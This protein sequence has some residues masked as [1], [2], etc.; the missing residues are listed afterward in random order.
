MRRFLVNTSD[1][2]GATAVV[3]GPDAHHITNV[4]RLARG[5]EIELLDGSGR[6]YSA[7][8]VSV[9]SQKVEVELLGRTPFFGESPL[10]LTVAQAYLKSKKMD[11]LIRQLTELGIAAWLP[12]VSQRSVPRPDRKSLA[13]RQKRWET[14]AREALKQCRRARVPEVGPLD[15]FEAVLAA[16]QPSALKIVFWEE[17]KRDLRSLAQAWAPKPPDRV[18]VIVGPEGGFTLQEIERAA[19]CGFE[20]CSLGPRILKAETAAVAAGALMQ[21]LFGDLGLKRS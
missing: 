5:D 2:S 1:L 20:S 10:E 4:L 6:G 19:A 16:A 14:I 11:I 12:F 3:S 15:S 13:A 7:R 8:I 21:Y 18:F 9:S 17:E